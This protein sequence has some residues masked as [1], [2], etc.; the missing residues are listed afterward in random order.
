MDVCGWNA[1]KATQGSEGI[2]VGRIA[3]HVEGTVCKH[4]SGCEEIELSVREANRGWVDDIVNGVIS[5]ALDR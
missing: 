1:C 5:R 2:G 3:R 4:F